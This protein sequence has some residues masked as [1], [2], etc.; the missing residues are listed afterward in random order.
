MA[1]TIRNRTQ[2]A[3]PIGS[4]SVLV[5]KV[6]RYS[7]YVITYS[8]T[9]GPGPQIPVS[10]VLLDEGLSQVLFARASGI[11]ERVLAVDPEADVAL[12]GELIAEIEQVARE[13]SASLEQ[14]TEW[15]TCIRISKFTIS[16]DELPAVLL[17]K[18]AQSLPFESGPD[19]TLRIANEYSAE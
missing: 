18:L 9:M 19:G 1:E 14:A 16:S 3:A 4:V 12:L 2:T 6:S 13:N 8:P 10:M 17:S 15:E 11:W 7:L 5:K